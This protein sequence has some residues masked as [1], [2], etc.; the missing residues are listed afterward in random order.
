MND[1]ILFEGKEAICYFNFRL[2]D[3]S[4]FVDII[5]TESPVGDIRM[6]SVAWQKIK[7]IGDQDDKIKNGY[8]NDHLRFEKAKKM[9]K[10]NLYAKLRKSLKNLLTADVLINENLLWSLN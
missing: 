1:L 2:Q 10:E 5:F 9:E 8:L 3:K 7:F 4:W 6:H